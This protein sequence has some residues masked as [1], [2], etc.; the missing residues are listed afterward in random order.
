MLSHEFLPYITQRDEGGSAGPD[1]RSS[2]RF[3]TVPITIPV[4][5]KSKI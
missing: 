4:S 3:K 5:S 1:K 2:I